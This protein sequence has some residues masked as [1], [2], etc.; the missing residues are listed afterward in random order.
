LQGISVPFPFQPRLG[1]LQTSQTLSCSLR[2]EDYRECLLKVLMSEESNQNRESMGTNDLD[3]LLKCISIHV[4]CNSNVH[5]RS[6]IWWSKIKVLE[7]GTF[8]F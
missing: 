3:P 1:A 8:G 2:P 7:S 5:L 6:P 4:P